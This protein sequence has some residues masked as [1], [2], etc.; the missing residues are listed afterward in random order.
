M[1]QIQPPSANDLLADLDISGYL[2]GDNE[3]L[4]EERDS[5]N[6][7]AAEAFGCMAERPTDYRSHIAAVQAVLGSLWTKYDCEDLLEVV[8]EYAHVEPILL[9]LERDEGS[10][11]RYRD[12]SVHSFN[13]FVFGLRV[14]TRL[15]NLTGEDAARRLLKVEPET[16]RTVIPG[17]RD[18]TWRERLF[19][20]WTLMST[21]HDIAIP[22][23]HLGSVG[24]G[25]NRFSGVFGLEILGPSMRLDSVYPGVDEYFRRVS[26]IFAGDVTPL[27]DKLSYDQSRQDLYLETYL[28]H[29]LNTQDHG[30]LSGLLIYR[31]IEEIFLLLRGKAKEVFGEPATFDQYARCVLHQDISRASLAMSLHNLKPDAA[32]APLFLPIHFRRHPLTFLLIL[33]DG[34]Q[35]YLRWEGTSIVGATK[36]CCFPSIDV[37]AEGARV[38]LA[39]DFHLTG[40]QAEKDYL[41]E[42]ARA[43]AAFAGSSDKSD[44]DLA[45]AASLFLRLLRQQ[46]EAQIDLQDEF[47]LEMRVTEPTGVLVRSSGMDKRRE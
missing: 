43:A 45:E 22:L 25:L 4:T 5:I 3:R 23:E 11:R 29:K 24:K 30:V 44:L 13:V 15:I 33:A 40:E 16:I 2:P 37:S 31:K 36:F 32:G 26:A 14:L 10:G 47:Q 12:H 34:L 35:E 18:W 28:R 17:F 46:L 38:K 9:D 20:L 21:F 7:S 8:R 19:Y 1:E 41:K 6:R 39:V 42:Q 27:E